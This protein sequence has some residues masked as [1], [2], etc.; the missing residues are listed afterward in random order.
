MLMNLSISDCKDMPQL[1]E[2]FINMVKEGK[3]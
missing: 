1:M 3:L 2:R